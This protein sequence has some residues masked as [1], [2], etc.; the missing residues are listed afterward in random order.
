MCIARYGPESPPEAGLA[1]IKFGILI[2]RENGP[3]DRGVKAGIQE[4]RVCT[5]CI[6]F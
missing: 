3:Q 5:M 2:L 4:N 1:I 6:R